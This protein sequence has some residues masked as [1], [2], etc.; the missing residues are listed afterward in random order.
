VTGLPLEDLSAMVGRQL[1]FFSVIVP[2]WLVAAMCGFRRTREV[3]PACLTAGLSFAIVQFLVANYHGPWLVDILASIASIASMV[4]PGLSPGPGAAS[5]D[6]LAPARRISTA[7]LLA[8]L[9]WLVLA[10]VLSGMVP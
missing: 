5:S 1:P 3:W 4:V 10:H 9:S 6:E 8:W 2:F 7:A